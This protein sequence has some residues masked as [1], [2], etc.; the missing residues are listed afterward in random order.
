MTPEE[1]PSVTKQRAFSGRPTSFRDWRASSQKLGMLCEMINK[2]VQSAVEKTVL[3][4]LV[5]N[6]KGDVFIL[7]IPIPLLIG[8][9]YLT[10]HY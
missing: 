4:M 5:E 8:A 10:Y 2:K 3:F 1:K 7:P 9:L 6:V